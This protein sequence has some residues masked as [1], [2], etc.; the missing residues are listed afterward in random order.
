MP[1]ADRC[2]SLAVVL[3]T[4]EVIFFFLVDAL[5]TSLKFDLALNLVGD[6]GI[7]GCASTCVV[8]VGSRVAYLRRRNGYNSFALANPLQPLVAKQPTS[9]VSAH[10]HQYSLVA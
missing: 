6:L 7:V 9:R 3:S 5:P 2:L 1:M 10:V 4:H 8:S